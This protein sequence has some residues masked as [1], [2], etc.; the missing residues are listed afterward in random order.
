[1][2]EPKDGILPI[3]NRIQDDIAIVRKEQQAAKERL[4]AITDAVLNTQDE[5]SEI[6]KDNLRHLGLTTKHHMEFED[7]LE[8]VKSLKVRVSAL[9][10]RS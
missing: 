9:E 4:I 10:S 6:R 2:A 8:E 3:L 1:M 7:L 5:V